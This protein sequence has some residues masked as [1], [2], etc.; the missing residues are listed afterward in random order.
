MPYQFGKQTTLPFINS[1]SHVFYHFDLIHSDVRGPTPITTQGMS[2]YFVIFVD[3][4][5]RYTW[6]YLFNLNFIK[7]IVTL[8][9]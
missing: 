6:I 7:Y 5:S 9:K 3:D 2:C 8:P 4:F 1:V